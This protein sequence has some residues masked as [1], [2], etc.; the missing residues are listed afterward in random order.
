MIFK[1]KGL[2]NDF[3]TVGFY[4]FQ[5]KLQISSSEEMKKKIS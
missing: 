3:M 4:N 2:Y 1:S 5:K